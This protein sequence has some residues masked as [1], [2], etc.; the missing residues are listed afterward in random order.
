MLQGIK[1]KQIPENE[2]RTEILN[3]DGGMLKGCLQFSMGLDKEFSK[4]NSKS[5]SDLTILLNNKIAI[6]KPAYERRETI[7]GKLFNKLL[8]EDAEYIQLSGIELFAI[9][10]LILEEIELPIYEGEQYLV[11]FR[12]AEEILFK[13]K[14]K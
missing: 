6:A 1:L 2:F 13:L 11:P 10:E 14:G 5:K 12:N 4:K 3:S 8:A 7:F 9:A